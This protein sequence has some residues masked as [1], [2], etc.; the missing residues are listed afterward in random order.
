MRF[1]SP[2]AHDYS[3]RLEGREEAGTPNVVGDLRAAL[4]FPVKDRIG[5]PFIASR[6]AALVRQAIPA[7][8]GHPR[9]DLLGRPGAN[10]LPIL[11]FRLRDGQGGLVHHQ[12]VTRRVSDRHGIWA[13]GGCA[14]AGPYVHRLPEFNAAG[15]ARIRQAILS[16]VLDPAQDAPA[17]VRG[18]R[19]DPASAT[20]APMPRAAV[21]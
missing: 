2:G 9:I 19:C 7:W 8:P 17:L 12:L 20:F 15:S 3:P 13:R 16:G 5:V 4:A 21:A 18:G 1:V 11:A 6:N 10:R 14:C